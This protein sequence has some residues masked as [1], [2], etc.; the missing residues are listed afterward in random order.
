[1]MMTLIKVKIQLSAD[2]C[3]AFKATARL[4]YNQPP[5]EGRPRPIF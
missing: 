2:S 4:R 3:S 1:M 5:R